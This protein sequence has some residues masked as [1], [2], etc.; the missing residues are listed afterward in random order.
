VDTL[1]ALMPLTWWAVSALAVLLIIAYVIIMLLYQRMRK[2]ERAHISVQTFM[3]GKNLDSLLQ[4]YIQNVAH[5]N[6][7]LTTC[8]ARLTKVEEKQCLA[9]GRLELIRFNA[10]ENMGSN[11]SFALALLNQTGDGV[12][13]SC[14]HSREESR[15]YGKP[16]VKGQSNYQLSKEE[17]QVIDSAVNG[18]NP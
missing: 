10:F 17:K 1:T 18:P 9:P 16:I 3:S 6:A 11:Q 15:V 12:V 7:D 2:F 13:L 5:L 4:Q 8:E 14:I